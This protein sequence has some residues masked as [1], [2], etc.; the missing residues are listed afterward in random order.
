MYI[1]VALISAMFLGCYDVL[2]KV[3]LKQSNIYEVLFFYCLSGFGISLLFI[4]NNFSITLVD[5]LFVLLKSLIIVVNWLLVIKCLKKL[6]VSIV[7]GFSLVN[8]IFTIFGAALFF[9]EK[10]TLV[11]L[12]SLFFIFLG[13]FMIAKLEKKQEKERDN[14]YIVLLLLANVL[15]SCSAFVDK[16]MLNYLHIANNEVLILFLLFNSVIYGVIYL[17]KNKKIE[18]KKLKSNYFLILAGASI[19]LA[20]ITYYYALTL[21]KGDISIVSIVRKSSVIIATLLAS[22]FLKEKHLLKKLGILTIMLIGVVLP[23]LM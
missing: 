18:F 12:L 5:S 9:K 13:I 17:Y 8:T 20:D 14:R 19:A 15:A 4:G 3:S 1:V 10:I 11:H 23:V 16:Y 21:D 22:I 2:K 7:V 6:D